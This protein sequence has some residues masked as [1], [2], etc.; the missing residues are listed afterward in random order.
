[1]SNTLQIAPASRY[2]QTHAEGQT[3]THFVTSITPGQS[4]PTSLRHCHIMLC[5]MWQDG[6]SLRLTSGPT[7]WQ[8][9][10]SQA[11]ACRAGVLYA[12]LAM[13][14][15][16][17][18][19]V[20]SGSESSLPL[21]RCCSTLAPGAS[22]GTRHVANIRTCADMKPA[23]IERRHIYWRAPWAGCTQKLHCCSMKRPGLSQSARK[24]VP[25]LMLSWC[26]RQAISARGTRRWRAP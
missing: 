22:R 12:T 4:K 5:C 6:F 10:Y 11:F 14:H 16:P 3:M 8:P 25:S 7:T 26:E 2:P 18:Q 1:M 19:T 20:C 23:L 15:I 9:G 17:W 13:G 24:A 21:E